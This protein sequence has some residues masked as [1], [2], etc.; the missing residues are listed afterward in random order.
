MLPPELLA[1]LAQTYPESFLRWCQNPRHCRLMANFHARGARSS[2]NGEEIEFRLRLSDGIIAEMAFT[3]EGR[4]VL[5]AAGEAVCSL[6]EGIPCLQA[7]SLDESQIAAELG[8]IPP[9]D[10]FDLMLAAEALRACILN[11]VDVLR[12]PWKGP[13]VK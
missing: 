4:P 5:L 3:F 7:P 10:H 8:D 6:C 1:H 11:A 13:Y 12:H 2:A 9:S